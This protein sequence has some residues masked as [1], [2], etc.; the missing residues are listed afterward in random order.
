LSASSRCRLRTLKEMIRFVSSSF[1]SNSCNHSCRHKTCRPINIS[2]SRWVVAGQWLATLE[3]T[4][5][6][7]GG[8]LILSRWAWPTRLTAPLTPNNLCLTTLSIQVLKAVCLLKQT[9]FRTLQMVRCLILTTWAW[10]RTRTRIKRY[11]HRAHNVWLAS[12]CRS[13]MES[14]YRTYSQTSRS[15]VLERPQ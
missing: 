7:P 3:I 6:M 1:C 4:Q 10:S 12:K 14:H 13:R 9:R 8:H 11:T 15:N 5:L 2:S